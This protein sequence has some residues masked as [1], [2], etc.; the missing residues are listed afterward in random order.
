MP[1]QSDLGAS[2]AIEEMAHPSGFEP[3][4]STFGGWRSIQLSYGCIGIQIVSATEQG[5]SRI[6]QSN[7][8]KRYGSEPCRSSP[9]VLYNLLPVCFRGASATFEAFLLLPSSFPNRLVFLD[10][11]DTHDK[12]T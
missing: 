3:E 9:Y 11:S 2:H 8:L 7:W 5:Q 1:S 10:F 6:Q 4:A 12:Q